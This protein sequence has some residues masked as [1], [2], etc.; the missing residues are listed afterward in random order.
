[1]YKHINRNKEYIFTFICLLIITIVSTCSIKKNIHFSS[2]ALSIGCAEIKTEIS[3]HGDK[4]KV[5]EFINKSL[6]LLTNDSQD[7]FTDIFT[8]IGLDK[9][10]HSNLYNIALFMDS[11]FEIE[12]YEKYLEYV[13]IIYSLLTELQKCLDNTL[14]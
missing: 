7:K 9:D 6:V 3:K 4:D 5:Q 1:M 10:K 12:I 2:I 13:E 11:I 14:I 8:T